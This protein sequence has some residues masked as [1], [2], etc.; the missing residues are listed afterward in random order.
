LDGDSP[1][2][3]ATV[4]EGDATGRMLLVEAGSPAR[5]SLGSEDLDLATAELARGS[6]GAGQST[7]HSLAGR[8]IFLDV[9]P[10]PPSLVI[11]GAGEDAKPLVAL[12]AEVGFRVTL[13]DYRRGLL[14]PEWFPQATQRIVARAEEPAAL[15]PSERS[16]AV[17]KTHSLAQ[18]REWV[19]RLLAAGFPY[20]GLLGPRD[21]TE[22]ILREIGAAGDERVYGPVGL[23]LGADG[24]RQVAVSIVA[25][26]LAFTAK[27]EPRHLCQRREAI[28]A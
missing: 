3:V 27:R 4:V 21:R 13:V 23:D 20:V 19:R 16:L 11:C 8:G 14:V 9:A 18:D 5:G 17:V 15:P 24:P 1:F 10:P 22:T 26:L 6:L 28:H 12:A 25:E 2:A 7:V